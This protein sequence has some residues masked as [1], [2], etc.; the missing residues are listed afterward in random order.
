MKRRRFLR[1]GLY[2]MTAL[3]PLTWALARDPGV[4][5][6]IGWLSAGT[7]ED[8]VPLVDAFRQG[9]SE[10]GYVEGESYVID[11][12]WRA[13]TRQTF[14]EMAREL[15]QSRPDLV[16]ATCRF[17]SRAALNAAPDVPVVVAGGVD[18]VSVGLAQSL[19][20]P[21]GNVTGL[22]DLSPDIDTKRLELLKEAVP[23]AARI[24]V[25][26]QMDSAAGLHAMEKLK[27]AAELL[28]V[29]LLHHDANRK[30]DHTRLFDEIQ[31]EKADAV[32][33]VSGP[34]INFSDRRTLADLALQSRLPSSFPTYQFVEAGGMMSL[35]V[36]FRVLFRRSAKYVDKILKGARP[37]ELPIEQPTRF[38]LTV[39]QK[40]AEA[41]GIDMPKSIMVR[42]DRI[43]E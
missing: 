37:G 30:S 12:R 40:T 43:V 25:L 33:L 14:D 3:W 31:S 27:P 23:H 15:M 8:Y 2:G 22:T 41:L 21:G 1:V 7:M 32:L 4:P 20:R 16:L 11:F 24:A 36:D 9:M 42:A 10:L 18:L 39:N 5:A 38:E 19:A 6:R 28:G 34:R 17:S 26:Y 35:G 29:E 13:D